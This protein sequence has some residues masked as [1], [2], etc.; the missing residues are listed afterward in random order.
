MSDPL[1]TLAHIV[2]SKTVME[3]AKQAG[4]E[5]VFASGW[6]IPRVEIVEASIAEALKVTLGK[7][8]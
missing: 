2:I 1:A 5:S 7:S 3:C 8:S 6:Q 4:H